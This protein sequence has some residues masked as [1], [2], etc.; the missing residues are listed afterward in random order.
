[1]RDELW[2]PL[3]TSVGKL[4]ST[5]YKTTGKSYWDYTTIVLTSEF[6]RMVSGDVAKIVANSSLNEE[7]KRKQILS[8]DIVAHNPVTSCAFMGPRVRGG[9]QFGMVGQQTMQPIPVHPQ[10]GE[11][12]QR[13]DADG[14]LKSGYSGPSPGFIVANH[15][16]TYATALKLA[17]INPQG[18]GRNEEAFL[19]FVL[20]A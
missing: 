7:E 4:K 17:G 11:L 10:T 16:H 6:G 15:G 20:R 5:E 18:V 8:Q 2:T 14:N 19:P 12:D 3:R 1:M 9:M 13:F